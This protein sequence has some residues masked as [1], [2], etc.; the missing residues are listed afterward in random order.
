[1][2]CLLPLLFGGTETMANDVQFVRIRRW[3]GS[4]DF[5]DDL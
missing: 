5:E 3:K 2:R 4:D 1:M